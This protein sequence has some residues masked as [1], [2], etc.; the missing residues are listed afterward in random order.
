MNET[1]QQI[2]VLPAPHVLFN[3]IPHFCDYDSAVLLTQASEITGLPGS[4]AF[5]GIGVS[6]EGLF[7][8]GMAGPGNFELMYKYS[9]GNGCT[10]SAFQNAL[11]IAPP[12]VSAGNDTSVVVNQPLQLQAVSDPSDQIRY[13]WSPVHWLSD[14]AIANPMA[15]FPIDP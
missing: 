5:S 1:Q 10:D 12:K 13:S 14:P 9:N 4:Y 8:P 7:V 6:P 11:V 2:I 3:P 15:V